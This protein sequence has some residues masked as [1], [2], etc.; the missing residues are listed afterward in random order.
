MGE[1]IQKAVEDV[2]TIRRIIDRADVKAQRRQAGERAAS[3]VRKRIYQG[4]AGASILLSIGEMATGGNMTM[5][6]VLS[7][8]NQVLKINTITHAAA[9]LIL[10]CA[11]LYFLVMR[12]A[13]LS[14]ISLDEFIAENFSYLRN[15]SLVSD[16][17]VKCIVFSLMLIAGK[18]EWIAP[19]FLL[20][21]AD[22]LVQGKVLF[23]P[24]R[25]SFVAAAVLVVGSVVQ[26]ISGSPSLLW[27][28][29]SMGGLSI[30][31][32]TAVS[33]RITKHQSESKRCPDEC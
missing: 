9:S 15:L 19:L 20:F 25:W 6:L 22:I 16:L 30:L 29:L 33:S 31:A 11:I 26:F 8:T 24:I 17:I 5:R 13:N 2:A 14:R 23:L 21:T 18:P 1:D 32:L 4:I 28:L 7:S 27:P 12:A 10:V 3:L